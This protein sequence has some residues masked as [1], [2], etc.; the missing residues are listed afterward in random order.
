MN[1]I[2]P[3]L[4]RCEKEFGFELEWIWFKKDIW[5]FS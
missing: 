4:A 1:S 2:F 5:F 3:W